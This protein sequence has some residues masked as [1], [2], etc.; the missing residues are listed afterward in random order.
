MELCEAETWVVAWGRWAA[1]YR[2]ISVLS[3]VTE[4]QNGSG[5]KGH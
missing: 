4:P 5:W 2:E 3:S 1:K